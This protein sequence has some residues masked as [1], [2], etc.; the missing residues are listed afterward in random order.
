MFVNFVRSRKH[1]LLV[2][3]AVLVFTMAVIPS[4]FTNL[5]NYKGEEDIA[6]GK[7][8]D[9][10]TGKATEFRVTVGHDVV[11]Q[12]REPAGLHVQRQHP[13]H[14]DVHADLAAIVRSGPSGSR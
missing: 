11:G 13:A 3:F 4:A 14:L 7:M 8:I 6:T 10:D 5:A 2:L 12:E 1:V 9:A